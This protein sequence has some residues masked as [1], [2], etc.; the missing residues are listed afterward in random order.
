MLPIA[1][2][3]SSVREARSY[4][5]SGFDDWRQP[6]NAMRYLTGLVAIPERKNVSSISRSFL[7]YRN[8]ASMNSFIADSTWGDGESHRAMVQ[9]VKDE[10]E[11]Q[12]VRH[13]T[14]VID[15]TFLEKSGEE[16]EG[17]GWFWDHSQNQSILAHNLV[18]TPYIASRFHVPLD[19][20]VYV[21]RKDCA[22][23]RMEHLDGTKV[24]VVV[25]YKDERLGAGG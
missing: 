4:L 24:K 20:D 9:M 1:E 3:P 21:K 13:G 19:F 18:S 5:E 7:E 14:L 15:D 10:A 17:V 23:L 6:E 8:Q 2:Y 12:G 22:S 11:K 16:M 25:P